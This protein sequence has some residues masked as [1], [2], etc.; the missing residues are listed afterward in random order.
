M[1]LFNN[2]VKNE[3]ITFAQN[4]IIKLK[5]ALM[6][7]NKN[8]HRIGVDILELACG[9]GG[10]VFKW[11]KSNSN[12]RYGNLLFILA[13][14]DIHIFILI[15]MYIF[16]HCLCLEFRRY[17]GVDIALKSLEEFLVRIQSDQNK[18]KIT[19]LVKCD[20]RFDSLTNDSLTTHTWHPVGM[21]VYMNKM[22]TKYD[23]Y[24][25][26]LLFS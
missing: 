6:N 3:L 16:I 26:V 4:S 8:D 18:H 24:S 7:V 13:I 9:M 23:N 22:T 11:M 10:D 5:S 19:Q 20:L 12:R 25:Q 2:W 15:Y 21:Y 17:V 1:R 14:V